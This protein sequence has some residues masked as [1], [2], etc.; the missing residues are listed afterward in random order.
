MSDRFTR[1]QSNPVGYIRDICKQGI[2]WDRIGDIADAILNPPYCV[3]V[4]SAN[5][6]G[7][8]WACGRFL[9]WFHDCFNPGIALVTAPTAV[10]VQDGV[11]KE[12]RASRNGNLAGFMPKATYAGDAGNHF[13]RG[14]TA[15]NPDAF[16]GRHERHMMMIFDEATGVKRVFWERVR[17]FVQPH[18]GHSWLCFYNPNDT[19]SPAYEYEQSGR[20]PVVRLSALE[21]P[22]I[23][24]QL[25]GREPPIPGAV[26]LETIRERINAECDQIAVEQ[27]DH[28]TDFEFPVGS[29]KWYRARTPTFD[30]QVRG[31]WPRVGVEALWPVAALE[32]AFTRQMPIQPQWPVAIGCDVARFGHNATAIVVRRGLALVHAERHYGVKSP[33]VIDRLKKLAYEHSPD[34]SN[35]RKVPCWIDDTGGYGSGVVD[36]GEGFNFHGISSSSSAPDGRHRNMRCYLWHL[37]VAAAEQSGIDCTRLQDRDRAD[38]KAE[39]ASVKAW[40]SSGA[41]CVDSK[42]DIKALLGRSPDL[43]D[44]ANLSFYPG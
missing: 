11:W 6:L 23:L 4:P 13:V 41:R 30:P 5:N 10:Q 21:H 24:A 8:T 9:S 32:A 38:L 27:I 39:W 14:F 12:F 20:M 7:K 35:F 36:H 1:Y 15:N 42:D 26:R 40:E 19:T 44:A 33:F 16:Q 29:G 37:P 2:V 25:E 28:T 31:R 17:T 3:L 34:K 43:A 18:F 22:N